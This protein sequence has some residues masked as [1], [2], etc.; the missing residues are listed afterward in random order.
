MPQCAKLVITF[1]GLRTVSR[2]CESHVIWLLYAC[3]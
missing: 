2:A 1:C 3:R